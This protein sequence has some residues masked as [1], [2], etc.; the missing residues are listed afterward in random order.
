MT[1]YR[2]A[3]LE[4]LSRSDA[5]VTAQ[6]IADYAGCSVRTVKKLVSA[7]NGAAGGTVLA[8]HTG[9]RLS[10]QQAAEVLSAQG[11][12]LP[13]TTGGRALFLIEA[14]LRRRPSEGPLD[15]F[16][17]AEE[18]RVSD[19]TLKRAVH[20]AREICTP[21]GLSLRATI[22][23]IEISGAESDK[24][25]LMGALYHRELERSG[26]S[27]ESIQTLFPR[28]D[29]AWIQE[30]LVSKCR[31]LHYYVNGYKLAT[32]LIDTLIVLDR[33]SNDFSVATERPPASVTATPRERVLAES[34][35]A[36]FER[37]YA[38]S[39]T[40]LELE[41]FTLLLMSNLLRLDDKNIGYEDLEEVVGADCVRLLEEVRAHM[42]EAYLLEFNTKSLY[43]RF[44]I[45]IFN[46]LR[47]AETG[48]ASP[49]PLTDTVKYSSPL[50]YDC[51]SGIVGVIE[52]YT[53]LTIAEDET[54]YIA[55]H[56]GSLVELNEMAHSQ[57]R[58][59][60][61][62][63]EYH[64]SLRRIESRVSDRFGADLQIVD[65]LTTHAELDRVEWEF[66]ISA[67]PLARDPAGT[68]AVISSLLP[69]RDLDQIARK[70]DAIKRMRRQATLRE[71]LMEVSDAAL[72]ARHEA[73]TTKE[74]LIRAMA[75]DLVAQG[76]AGADF[77]ESV[78]QR[79][80]M[81][82]TAFDLVAVPHAATLNGH[83]TGLNVVMYDHPVAWGEKHVQLV[84]MF[85]VNRDEVAV[86]RAVFDD[87]VVL[88][89]D[90]ANL[91]AV[92]RARSHQEFVDAVV[93]LSG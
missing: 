72:F 8:D 14:A 28:F 7:I 33:L 53:G 30:T 26:L 55:L 16:A 15:A 47:R 40:D 18:L 85:T 74:D 86:F 41:S 59:V 87:L 84:L 58:T 92:L 31:G 82:S 83:R 48:A 39:F 21:Y 88:L 34:V 19:S 78:L 93:T 12:R 13:A 65:V 23:R 77:V 50:L 32:L 57:I 80:A 46:L 60:L 49:S 22:D 90:R 45:H 68:T 27:V 2:R 54:A 17:L 43:V 79:E 51:A 66:L 63:P 91:P 4:C 61:L 11:S 6:A 70:I 89:S 56:L 24:R 69:D 64:D 36:E 29:V 25:R 81:I 1:D 42:R 44:A 10:S 35:A 9:Y 38:L 75:G 52:S 67:V 71:Q 5:P 73:F 62:V 76:Y 3:I 37:R 20:H